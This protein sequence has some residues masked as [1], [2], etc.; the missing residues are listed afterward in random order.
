[1]GTGEVST[2]LALDGHESLSRALLV[3][4]AAVWILL[5]IGTAIRA[6]GDPNRLRRE[7]RSP[8]ALT[9]VAGTSVLGVRLALLGWSWIPAALLCLALALWALLLGP[10]LRAWTRPVPGSG[11]LLAVSTQSLAV[12][13]AVL[14]T[15]HRLDWLLGAALLFFCLGLGLYGFVATGFHPRELLLGRGDHWIAGGALAITT[16][17]AAHLT[18]GVEALGGSGDFHALVRDASL[19]LWVLSMVWLPVLVVTELLNPRLSFDLRRWSTVFPVAMYA[20]S[21][22]VV[23]A[24]ASTG[25]PT[26]FARTWVWIAVALW[27][28]VAAA[29]AV[30]AVRLRRWSGGPSAV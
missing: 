13:A 4:A 27:A 24:A 9:A 28:A 1:M 26:D 30:A 8:M 23:G 11:F 15:A 22:F 6:A 7:A 12:L 20:T 25:V 16:L 17:A 5:A 18:V 14:A 19:V 3:A 29:H 10:V 21:S 2:A